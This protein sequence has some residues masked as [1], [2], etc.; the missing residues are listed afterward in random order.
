MAGTTDNWRVAGRALGEGKL[1]AN[2]AIPGAGAR[3]TL[4]A[5][6]NTP[7]ATANPNAIHLG[8]T[9]AGAKL[10][11]KPSRQDFFID[12][13]VAP[14]DSIITGME[15]AISAELVGVTDMA[16]LEL[17]TSG[18][19]T[20][21]TGSGYEEISFGTRAD[22]FSSVALIAP[23][24]DDPAKVFVWHLYKAINDAGLDFSQGKKEM[25]FVP[26]NFRGYAITT[27]AI[28]DQWGKGW[29]QTT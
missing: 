22:I 19:G 8:G 25:S 3:L 27:R 21:S 1:Y 5:T 16:L 15:M 11:V 18:F 7:D 26:V 20:K 4:D 29:K 23:L 24:R 28:A 2:L 17:L 9:K 14:V 13:V 10:M 12:E 6:T